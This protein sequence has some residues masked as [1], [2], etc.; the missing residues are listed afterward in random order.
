MKVITCAFRRPWTQMSIANFSRRVTLF[1]AIIHGC[2]HVVVEQLAAC[3]RL[4]PVQCRPYSTDLASVVCGPFLA[5][6]Q[7]ICCYGCH[8]V[9]TRMHVCSSVLGCCT[10]PGRHAC[11]RTNTYWL[12]QASTRQT[13]VVQIK[14]RDH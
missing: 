5:S 4:A 10:R 8:G 7:L 12:R 13:K 2:R 1:V 6:C 11:M 3:S 14:L 9:R